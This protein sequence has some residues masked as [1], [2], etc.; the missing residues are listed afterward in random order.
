MLITVQEFKQS[1]LPVAADIKDKEI[2]I[3]IITIEEFYLK[4][5]ITDQHYTDLLS[6]PTTGNNPVILNG[7]DL[8]GVH[9]AGLKNALYHIIYSYLLMDGYRATRFA[10][11]EKTSEYSKPVSREDLEDNA[12]IHWNIGIAFVQEVQR[13]YNIDLYEGIQN[14]LFESIVL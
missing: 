4:P 1:G 13:F 5:R 11:V 14:T 6:N 7:G 8:N 12:R 9:L 10:S 3:A 2:E